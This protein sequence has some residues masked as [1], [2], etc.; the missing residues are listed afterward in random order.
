M[1]SICRHSKSGA[2]IDIF[3]H[4]RKQNGRKLPKLTILILQKNNPYKE[5]LFLRSLISY[6]L[7]IN[8]IV[9]Q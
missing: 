7:V 5:G 9:H 4:I 1:W 6:L 2:K 8:A 3:F